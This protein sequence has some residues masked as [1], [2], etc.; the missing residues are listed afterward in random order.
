MLFTVNNKDLPS[1]CI[2]C[3]ESSLESK[4]PVSLQSNYFTI[5]CNPVLDIHSEFSSNVGQTSLFLSSYTFTCKEWA[6]ESLH[7]NKR[8]IFNNF[9]IKCQLN[10]VPQIYLIEHP[11]FTNKWSSS[12][13][14]LTAKYT[15]QYSL[16][17][18]FTAIL[19]STILNIHHE[20][21]LKTLWQTRL[22]FKIHLYLFVG[23]ELHKSVIV[24]LTISWFRDSLSTIKNLEST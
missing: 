21:S 1:N 6:T 16:Y 3:I 18:Y 10:S 15:T 14:S 20:F 24:G 5:L 13:R 23:N 8:H 9:S 4:I 22:L 7:D 11:S 12:L 2:D 17:N 19:A